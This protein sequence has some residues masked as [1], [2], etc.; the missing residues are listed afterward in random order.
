[1]KDID[2]FIEYQDRIEELNIDLIEVNQF[3]PR[4]RFNE[5]EEDELIDSI[6]AKGILNPINSL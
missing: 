5:A 6:L 2:P 4:E 1:M 3:N